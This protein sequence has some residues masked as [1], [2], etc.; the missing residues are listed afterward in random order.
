M[1]YAGKRVVVVGGGVGIGRAVARGFA[2]EGL[3]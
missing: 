1:R 2:R 3:P